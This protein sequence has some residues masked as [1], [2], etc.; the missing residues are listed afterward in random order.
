M[1]EL[2]EISLDDKLTD[3]ALDIMLTHQILLSSVTSCEYDDVIIVTMVT[4]A[5]IYWMELPHPLTIPNKVSIVTKVT[6][7]V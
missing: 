4:T 7:K 1:L 3:N 6:D 2:T 5:Q